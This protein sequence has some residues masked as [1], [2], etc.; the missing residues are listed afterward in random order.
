MTATA[1]CLL[2]L[3][4]SKKE[5]NGRGDDGTIAAMGYDDDSNENQY[6]SIVITITGHYPILYLKQRF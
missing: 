1:R 3:H 4:G 5:D 2:Q 6:F